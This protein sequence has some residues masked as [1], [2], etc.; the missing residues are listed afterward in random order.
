MCL[1]CIRLLAQRDASSGPKM[2]MSLTA[3]NAVALPCTP[4]QHLTVA[5]IFG[6]SGRH[7]LAPIALDFQTVGAS[8]Q[9][10]ACDRNLALM[11]ACGLA[12]ARYVGQ[13]QSS[14]CH[15]AIDAF[16]IVLRG[17]RWRFTKAQ[18]PRQPL[19]GKSAISWRSSVGNPTSSVGLRLRPSTQSSPRPSTSRICERASPILRQTSFHWSSPGQQGRARNPF[20]LRLTPRLP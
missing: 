1:Q 12:P 20:F 5:A 7:G 15:D 13:Q 19:L 18:A 9:V 3:P 6:E 16:G 10:A 11:R 2:C 4:S 17:A 8:P 14:L